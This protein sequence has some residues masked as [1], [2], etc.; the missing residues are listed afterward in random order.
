[1]VSYRYE[2]TIFRE[3][4]MMEQ[5]CFEIENVE[6]TFLDKKVL[7]IDRLAVHQFDRIGVV[8]KTAQEKYFNKITCRN[9]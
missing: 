8:G 4:A 5:I 2:M 3:V 7:E 9:R 1:M 6:V